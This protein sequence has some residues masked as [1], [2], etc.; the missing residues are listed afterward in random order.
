MNYKY[1]LLPIILLLVVNCV[2]AAEVKTFVS[3]DCSFESLENFVSGAD[4]LYIG[5]YVFTN[6]CILDL[7]REENI[8]DLKILIESSPVHGMSSK[9]KKILCN[10]EENGK[11]IYLYKKEG[12]NYHHAKYLIKD[13]SSVLVTSENFGYTGFSKNSNYGNR[14]WGAIIEDENLTDDFLEIFFSDL[15]KA[16]KFKCELEDYETNCNPKEENYIPK[17]KTEKFNNQSVYSIFA[18]NAINEILDLIDSANKSI[19]IQQ[20]YIYKYWGSRKEGSVNKTPNLF[21]ERVINK[22]REG[23]DVKIL[24]DSYWYNID[25]SDPVSNYYTVEY[26]NQ[27][28]E[29]ENITVEARLVDLD[30]LR[31]E[32]IHNKGMI[33][34]NKTVL[35]STINWN[36]H[37]PKN[38]REVGVVIRG[39]VAKYYS[40]VF[41]Y[42]WS[43]ILPPEDENSGSSFNRNLSNDEITNHN[44]TEYVPTI[45]VI[46]ILS[47]ILSVYFKTR[48]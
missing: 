27:I 47:I 8:S 44:I 14:G 25:K 36:E 28:A 17:F 45:F 19:Y 11:K 38:N 9:E 1:F 34:D 16:E 31:F 4:S 3:P 15:S 42:D 24:L 43:G 30:R 13:N 46:I 6:P 39:E 10:L 26:V 37:S 22:S 20:M 12:R 5:T 7:L 29:E 21:L 41:S 33:I 48:K 23:L 35:I 40:K 2:N 18:P 32:K